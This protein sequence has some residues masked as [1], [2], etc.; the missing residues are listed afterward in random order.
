QNMNGWNGGNTQDV[1]RIVRLLM[2]KHNI[3]P[4][5]IYIHGLSNGG[6]AVYDA[7]KR[8]PW[9]FAGALTMSA[10]SDG[11]IIS[12]NS[13]HL[14]HEIP[15]WTFQGGQDTN[16]T[17]SK[18][19]GYV[20]K[21]RAAGMDVRYSYYPTLG[22]GTWNTAYNEPDFFTWMLTKNKRKIHVPFGIPVICG[23]NGK[24]VDLSLSPG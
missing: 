21:F 7:I 23:T 17:P 6:A 24:G 11:T 20:T 8:A 19:Q 15:I 13:T 3:D 18:T 14:V 10:I 4:D 12:S 9:L 1:I 22:H 2:K 16:P 5:R